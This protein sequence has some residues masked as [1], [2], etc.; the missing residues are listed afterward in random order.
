MEYSKIIGVSCLS[1]FG[2]G[3]SSL[4]EGLRGMKSPNLSKRKVKVK[5]EEY[6]FDICE[7]PFFDLNAN[8]SSAVERRMGQFCRILYKTV[9]MA[10][11]DSKIQFSDFSK[12]GLI[13]GTGHG[14][15]ST[16]A[17]YMSR[18]TK[19]GRMGASP[20]HFAA[21]MHNTAASFISI[22]LGITGPIYTVSELEL[23]SVSAFDQARTWLKS[24]DLDYVI[25]AVGDEY[26]DFDGYRHCYERTMLSKEDYEPS[27]GRGVFLGE[28]AACL[29]L[30]KDDGKSG[31]YSRI[32]SSYLNSIDEVSGEAFF[33]SY[34]GDVSTLDEFQK[35]TSGKEV[36]SNISHYGI[37][38]TSAILDIALYSSE[39]TSNSF[40]QFGSRG[41]L[42]GIFLE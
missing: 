36:K 22:A 30:A 39:K 18:L 9:L 27:L 28:G 23:T 13:V 7:V 3:V 41:E 16:A 2:E 40:I 15:S 10:I 25:V 19:H 29:I 1:T 11:E 26:N 8:I 14:P 21:S 12:V 38:P 5:E 6:E 4:D 32:S 24:S 37:F 31:R 17:H 33:V 35:I 42:G 20:M 34:G